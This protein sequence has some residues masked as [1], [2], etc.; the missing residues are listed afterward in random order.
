[1]EVIERADVISKDFARKFKE[2]IEG[3]RKTNDSSSL[4]LVA[5][6]DFTYLFNLA[7]GKAAL[8]ADGVRKRIALRGLKGAVRNCL[9]QISRPA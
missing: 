2:K 4:P 9:A 7:T 1:M 8:P 5:Q 3:N 6:A